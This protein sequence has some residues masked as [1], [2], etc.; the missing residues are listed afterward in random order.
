MLHIGT[1]FAVVPTVNKS[2]VA[3]QMFAKEQRVSARGCSFF[4]V[5]FWQTWEITTYIH[6]FYGN[7]R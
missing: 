5:D 2:V 3:N 1:N 6:V 7:E 4:I